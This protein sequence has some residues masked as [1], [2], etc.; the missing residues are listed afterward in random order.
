MDKNNCWEA[1]DTFR[2]PKLEFSKFLGCE[3]FKKAFENKK[4]FMYLQR[5]VRKR[6]L[7]GVQR[8]KQCIHSCKIAHLIETLLVFNLQ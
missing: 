7:K 8:V 5:F 6:M 3:K 1:F 4:V 2:Y